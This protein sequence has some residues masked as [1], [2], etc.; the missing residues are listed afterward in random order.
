[1]YSLRTSSIS[2]TEGELNLTISTIYLSRLFA[3]LNR[4]SPLFKLKTLLNTSRGNKEEYLFTSTKDS[5]IT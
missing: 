4:R 2:V 3:S 5:L 1:M